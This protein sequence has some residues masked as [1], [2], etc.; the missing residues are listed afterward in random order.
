MFENGIEYIRADFHLHTRK[1][2]EF[3]YTGEENDFVKLYVQGLIDAGIGIGVI[4]NH[5]KFDENEYKAIRRSAKKQNIL[6]LPGVE[7]S[8]KEGANGI[9]TLIIFNPDEWIQNGDNH[10][11]SFFASAFAGISNPENRNT[12]CNYDLRTMFERLD[13]YGKDY[14]IVFAHVDQG[15]GLFEECKG[16]MLESIAETASF[17]KRVLGLQKSRTYSNLDKFKEYFGYLP[18]LVEGSDPKSI[19]Q[20]GK[21]DKASFLKIGEFSYSAVK[22]ALQDH[23]NR[24]FESKPSNNH[25][26]I[27]SVSFQGGKFDGQT[28]HFSS[29]LNTLIGIR[30]SGKSAILE[31]IRYILGIDPQADK[32]YKT[33]LI[34]NIWGSGGK[35]TLLIHDKHGRKYYISRI[36][37]ERMTVL[38]ENGDDLIISPLSLLDGVQYFGQKDLSTSADQENELLSKLV[39]TSINNEDV[40]KHINELITMYEQ[41]Q[42]FSQIPSQL[43]ELSTKIAETKHKLSIY[44]E[45]GIESKLKKQSAYV[46]DKAKM[47]SVKSEIENA[48]SSI[49]KVVDKYSQIATDLP[50]YKSEYNSDLFL[51]LVQIVSSINVLLDN[52]KKSIEQISEQKDA[53]IDVLKQLEMIID[54]LTEEFAAVKREIQDSTIDTDAFTEMKLQLLESKENHSKLSDVLKQK[55]DFEKIFLAS[56]RQRNEDLNEAFRRYQEEAQKINNAQNE[57]KIEIGFKGDKDSFKARIKTDFRGTGI[58]D[59]K[60]SLIST[61]F[62]D[63]V[64]II[65]E[66][67]LYDGKR[68]KELLSS[69]EYLK[70]CEKMAENYKDLIQYIVPDK[71]EIFYH[72]KLLRKHSLGQRASALILFILTQ[73]NND[74]IIIDQPEDDLDNKVIYDEVI[75]AISKTKPNVQFV[76]ATHNANI[77]V[78]GDAERVL[79]VDFH[80]F[81]IEVHQG[82]I[83]MH[84]TQKQIIDIMEGGREAFNKRKMIYTSWRT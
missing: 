58:S 82:N 11:Q 59:T 76:F 15:N 68:L 32:S 37:N 57:L 60:Y 31:S 23:S 6:I 20:I 64:D 26:F 47:T 29:S 21:G 75:S 1:D 50:E 67:V 22:F 62:S 35:A 12:R 52:I 19:I 25:G 63:Y 39:G 9:H 4:T 34:K 49:K 44:K 71:V 5:N 8:V 43:S 17:Q 27:E 14:F 74:I 41:M 83:D 79:V 65:A 10:I 84:D 7:L 70:F 56:V 24:V 36:L 42:Q 3:K 38:D 13:A 28:I 45:K 54:S 77:P 48:L 53:T 55:S 16:G 78:L 80:E 73:N 81:D 33:D 61:S 66:I 18:A 46:S 69:A 2:K 51:K 40:T 72:E 30:G